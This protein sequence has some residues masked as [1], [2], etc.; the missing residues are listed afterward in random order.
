MR[1]PD[2]KRFPVYD[3]M[4]YIGKP[5]TTKYGL[6]PSNII[7]DAHIWPHGQ[8]YGVLP[9]RS[10]FDALVAANNTNPGPTVL[11]T[12]KLPLKGS[13]S[14]IQR[15]LQVLATLADWTRADAP[16]KTVGYYGYHTL[17]GVPPASRSYAQQ[18][19]RHVDAFFPSMYTFDDDQAAWAT[20]AATEAAEDRALAAGK[21]VFFTSGRNTMTARRSSLNISTPPTGNF[22]STRLTSTPMASCCGARAA[23]PG[24]K[25]AAGGRQPWSSSGKLPQ[26]PAARPGP[27]NRGKPRLLDLE[28]RIPARDRFAPDSLLEGSEF[29][30]SVPRYPR[31][32]RASPRSAIRAEHRLSPKSSSLWTCRWRELGSSDPRFTLQRE[33]R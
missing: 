27:D 30:I 21:P 14:T 31:W 15:H 13:P 24:M 2:A 1:N 9:S 8:N 26:T 22:S 25:R 16:G 6:I 4:F 11:D 3:N 18:L 33:R 32:S 10:V 12:E 28:R 23:L 7:D 20:R 29:E 5:D 17:T 19:A